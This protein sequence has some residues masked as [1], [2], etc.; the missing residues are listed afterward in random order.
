MKVL[1]LASYPVE[2][3]ATRYR[4]AQ[5]VAPLRERG[6]ELEVRPFL[7][8]RLFASL[9]RRDQLPR[10]AAGLLRAA[11]ARTLDVLAARRADVVL[12]QREAMMFGPPV[13]EYLSARLGGR[14]LVLDLDD[15]TYVAYTS[16]TYGRLAS[17]LKWFSK[18]DDLI[19][20]ATVVTCG[21]RAI[22]E[23]VESKGGRAVLVPTVVDTDLFRPAERERVNEVTPVVGWV[24]THSTFPY[25]ESIFPVLEELARSHAFRL[26][27]V[28]AGRER[29][30]VAGVEVENLPWEMAREVEDFRSFDVGVYPILPSDWA[31]GKSGFKSV[32]Y[33]SVGVPFVATPLGA[34]TE[35]GEAGVTHFL[36]ATHGEWRDA[37][38]K[39]LADAP[40]RRRMGD[41][42]RAHALA[43]YTVPAQ[44]DKL[45][46]ALRG[47]ATAGGRAAR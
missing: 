36:A 14:P 8:S 7:D 33:M 2:A 47:A 20:W 22:A 15:A 5:Y 46:L 21:S 41:A 24:G 17:A 45:A 3:A 40:L 28:G 13:V 43:H 9:Y 1:G 31:A 25:L 32:Q 26:K 19:R 44:A 37:L 18:T 30:S 42:G 34:T 29:V 11:L 35:I 12:V 23:Y 6:I 10:T 39:L 16:P 4:L 38:A 27:I